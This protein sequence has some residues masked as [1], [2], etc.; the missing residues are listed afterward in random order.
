MRALAKRPIGNIDPTI[1]LFLIILL[2]TTASGQE[3]NFGP[4]S[5]PVDWDNIQLKT[6][7]LPAS[8]GT[9]LVVTNRSFEPGAA[10]GAIFPNNIS[11]YRK[12]TYLLATCASGNW[13]LS[14]VDDLFT[15]LK[16][17]DDGNDILLFVHG[18]G[19]SLPQVLIRSNQ[20]KERYD[21]SLVVF[22][23]PASNSNFNKSLS[24]VRRCGENF[25]NLLLQMKQY[26]DEEMKENQHMS[27]LMHSLGNYYLT[28]MVVNGN[29]QYLEGKIFDNII[30]NAAAVR[31]KE[32]GE[33]ISQVK[34]QE[35]LYV[36][37]N[38]RDRVLKGAHLLT[39]GKM[40][41]NLAME[42]LASNAT[43]IDFSSLAGN[44]HTYFAGYH[45]F[46]YE[47]TAFKYFFHGAFHGKDVDL[48]NASLF[49]PGNTAKVYMVNDPF[50]PGQ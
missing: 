4:C 38:E 36:V 1:L 30:M 27:L 47:M 37:Y 14:P 24:R 28:H 31:S 35:R 21:I 22:D 46:E 3:S 45:S 29:N 33:V 42:P 26:R 23:W 9:F 15:G 16:T 25:Y 50:S 7:E 11:D 32:H 2:T 10:D 48:S 5:L 49:T 41:G 44:E 6:D 8:A 18:H 40:L 12:V 39:S 43:Y 20:I 13:K 19:K 34:I 17:I